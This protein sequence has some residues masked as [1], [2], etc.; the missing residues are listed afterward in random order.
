MYW[1]KHLVLTL[2]LSGVVSA[3]PTSGAGYIDPRYDPSQRRLQA[4][5]TLEINV[6]S[7]PELEKRYQIR[8]DG[9]FFHPFAGQ[10]VASGKTLTQL[11][12][13]L[14]QKLSRQ[15]KKPHFRLG[16]SSMGE[17]EAA[18]LGEVRNQGKFKFV[19]GSSVMDLLAQAGG[20]SDKADLDGAVILRSGKSLTLDLSPAHQAELSR[21][22][23]QAG[24]I[25]YVNRGR[26]IGVSGEVQTN[27][28]Y[29]LSSKSLHPLEDSIKSA[30]GAK[31]TAALHRVQ[32]IRPS[33]PKPLE[34][35]L[36]K[37][38]ELAKVSLEDGDMVVVP[39]RKAVVLG[40]VTK[41]GAIPLNGNESLVDILSQA[42]LNSASIDSVVVIR[43]DN[44]R[45]ASTEQKEVYNLQD[46]LGQSQPLVNV[47]IHDGDLVYVPTKDLSGGVFGPAGQSMMSVLLMA[48]SLFAF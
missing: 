2:F 32:I 33:L 4:G 8:A 3:Q 21:M 13:D 37:P 20:V 47:P 34:V 38:D 12:Q 16:L 48:R 23:V 11:E 18:V 22:E 36:L 30:G 14:K 40:A 46:G 25:L 42:G 17:S 24:D 1:R 27:G 5:D 10:V 6:F 19:P 9:T 26:R 43:S 15:L 35:N 44:V 7:L 31:E 29:A 41:A 28:V 45:T 39:A